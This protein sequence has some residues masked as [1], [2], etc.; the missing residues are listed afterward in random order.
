MMRNEETMDEIRLME[1]TEAYA[2]QIWEYRARFQQS[3][4]DDGGCGML[5]D[6]ETFADWLS[7]T[8]AMTQPDTC[9]DGRV[10]SDCYMAIRISDNKLVG[11]IDLRHRF[12]DF[13]AEYGGNIGYS[14]RPSERGK[15]YAGY[16]LS[17]V[18]PFCREAG[19]DCVL[20]TCDADNE[21]SRRTI[22]RAGGVYESTVLN[23][24][25][26]EMIERYWIR[27]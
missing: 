9:P 11:M 26:N 8:R 25:E 19:L 21:A 3:A 22:L 27:L 16:M 15:G 4:E 1:P 6:C 23:P 18:L 2:D 20:I 5:L 10:P 13:L 14:V 7:V 17:A 24:Y 12:N